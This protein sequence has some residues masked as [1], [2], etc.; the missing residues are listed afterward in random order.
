MIAEGDN[1]RN[2]NPA[3]CF[4]LAFVCN[5]LVCFKYSKTPRVLLPKC[6]LPT[7]L[8][9]SA[10]YGSVGVS[11]LGFLP[12]DSIY[13]LLQNIFCFPFLFPPFLSEMK[14]NFATGLLWQGIAVFY[15][16][17]IQMRSIEAYIRPKLSCIDLV[18]P[19]CHIAWI[20]SFL[21]RQYSSFLH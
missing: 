21:K 18:V 5:L 10:W 2:N 16:C 20:P 11:S 1:C 14:E 13:N 19:A 3:I 15:E 4:T 8:L 9:A 12:C 17:E 6:E 7:S